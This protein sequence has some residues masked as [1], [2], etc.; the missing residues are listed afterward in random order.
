MKLKETGLFWFSNGIIDFH[1]N[2]NVVSF[3]MQSK[4]ERACGL[5]HIEL[6]RD[7]IESDPFIDS[8]DGST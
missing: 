1:A 3:F 8:R 2:F 7:E 6:F 4:I 5:I